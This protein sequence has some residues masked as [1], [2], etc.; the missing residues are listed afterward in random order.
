MC[1]MLYLATS[2]DQPLRTSPELSVEEVES[3]R[4][5][6]RQ[7][8]SLPTVHFIGAHT[9]CSCGFSSLIGEEP[10]ECLDGMFRDDAD[11]EADI[12]SVQSLLTRIRE[13]VVAA[14]EVQLYPVWDGN[15]DSPPKGTINLRLDAMNPETFVF[16]QQFL[17]LIRRDAD[18]SRL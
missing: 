10:V 7:W 8:F 15:E 13:H 4:E 18:E 3:S 17:Y 9:G 6:V 14:N 1:L 12:R 5:G 11:R 2:N 16:N